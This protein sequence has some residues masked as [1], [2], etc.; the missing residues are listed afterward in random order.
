MD[1]I[2]YDPWIGME[3]L[4]INGEIEFAKMLLQW[5]KE[6]GSFQLLPK[7][8]TDIDITT[9]KTSEFGLFAGCYLGL[10]KLTKLFLS[11][12][13]EESI[14]ANKPIEGHLPFIAI[15]CYHGPKTQV[16][17][18]VKVVEAL[19]QIPDLDVNAVDS[20]GCSALHWSATFDDIEA[21]TKLLARKDIKV[22]GITGT[23]P[24]HLVYQH[25]HKP[26]VVYALL[27]V[28]GI[29]VKAVDGQGKIPKDYLWERE[30]RKR[31]LASQKAEEAIKLSFASTTK[32][33]RHT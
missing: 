33:R 2:F 8:Y 23:T 30:I 10:E 24:L 12:P 28:K 18:K 22:N 1:A 7:R 11:D 32:R 31:R 19:L 15:S 14:N 27:K 17:T 25:T 29:D 20:K 13:L 16:T 6:N 4:L 9:M 3:R 26:E 5:L 21:M